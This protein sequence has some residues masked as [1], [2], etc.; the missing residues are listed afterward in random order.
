MPIYSYECSY[1]NCIFDEIR[2]INEGNCGKTSCKQCGNTAFK[3]PTTFHVKI[4][5]KRKFSDGTRTPDFVNTYKQE[6]NW[7]K[8]EG[9]TY[10]PPTGKERRRV[11][12]E[13]RKKSETVM[14]LA[15]KKALEDCEQGKKI[16]PKEA[17][18]LEKKTRKIT[19][20]I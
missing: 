14:E 18:E 5:K 9:I 19:F 7:M 20:N 6:K 8:A 17:V 12:E 2:K 1:C 4:F 11:T 16:H 13:R 10:D 3:I 15:F